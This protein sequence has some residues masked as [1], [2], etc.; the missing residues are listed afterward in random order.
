M[1]KIL[2]LARREYKASVQTKGFIIGL[3]LAPILMGGGIIGMVLMKDQVDTTD[4]RVAVVDRSGVVGAA[5]AAAAEERNA[6]AVRNPATGE[7]VKPAYLIE[8]VAPDESDPAA[9]RLALSER[10][11]RGALH[12]FVEVGP[13]VLHPGEDAEMAR[14]EY[15]ARNAAMDEVR[16]WIRW[17]LNGALRRQR[18]TEL[19]VA[20]EELDDVLFWIPVQGMGLVSVDAET[21]MVGKARQSHEGE[22]VAVPMVLMFLMFMMIMMGAVPLLNSVMEE[23]T[24]R[25]AEV[26]LGS[27]K[28]FEFMMGKVLGGVGVSLTGSVVYVVGGIAMVGAMG[29]AEFVPYRVLPWFFV[30]M[31]LAILMIGSMLAALG[32]ACSDPKDAQSLTLPAM[33]PVIAPMFVMMPV[34]REPQSGLAT[35]M[36]LFPPCTPLLMLARMATPGG[37][38]GWQPWVG[39]CGVIL[40]TLISVWAGGRIFRMGILLQGKPPK[41]GE[42]LRWAIRG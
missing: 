31:L 41:L 25:I 33:L 8:V 7:K 17:P 24:Q 30:F 20:A 6:A 11:R 39:L 23:K 37:V 29:F 19:G 40:F 35:W 42:M 36:S 38:P 12:G 2:R 16:R 32:A 34:L 18:L 15:Y 13:E 27:L 5:V 1:R 26:L 14:I 10:V 22:A 4:R 9:Q 3:V 21:G 28:P